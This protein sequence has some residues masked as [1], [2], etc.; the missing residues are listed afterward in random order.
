MIFSF[1]GLPLISCEFRSPRSMNP[2]LSW[3]LHY[4][5]L[6]LSLLGLTSMFFLLLR[7]A[8]FLMLELNN[9]RKK[10]YYMHVICDYLFPFVV[11][12]SCF[13]PSLYLMLLLS[14]SYLFYNFSNQVIFFLLY[15]NVIIVYVYLVPS[16]VNIYV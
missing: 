13:F 5:F 9:L 10:Y 14:L 6:L 16:H 1:V 7:N 12:G 11:S 2:W 3:L 8:S 15:F 4:L